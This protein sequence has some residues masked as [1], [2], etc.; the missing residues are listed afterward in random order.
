VDGIGGPSVSAEMWPLART[1]ITASLTVTVEQV[2]ESVRL[3][4]Q[5]ARVVVEGA[6]AAAFAAASVHARRLN[7]PVRR[8][9]CVLSG[10]NIDAAALSTILTGGVP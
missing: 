7:P 1:L 10:G 4:A 5:R 8:I 2:A 9:V 6:G 3:L